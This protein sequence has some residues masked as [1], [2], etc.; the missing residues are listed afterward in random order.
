MQTNLRRLDARD[1]VETQRV[2]GP[3]T[4]PAPVTDQVFLVPDNG[5]IRSSA[6]LVAGSATV[7]DEAR[8]VG[9][10][11]P[12]GT[13]LMSLEP[14]AWQASATTLFENRVTA[15]TLDELKYWDIVTT[16]F[17][18]YIPHLFFMVLPIS[19][20]DTYKALGQYSQAVAHY[21]SVLKYPYL[22]RALEGMDLWQRL[23][24][25]Q[26][27]WGDEL[28][29]RGSPA[30]ARPHY[31]QLVDVPYAVP[32]TSPLYASVAFS[33]VLPHAQETV[34]QL[35]GQPYGSINPRIA[36]AITAAARQLLKIDSGLNILGLSADY[37]P[38]LRFTYLQSAANYLA[39]NAIQAERTFVQFRSQAE[40]ATFE[41]M[42]L[43]NA[44]ALND[45]ALQVEIKRQED[46][47]LEVEAA[48]ETLALTQVRKANAETN[49]QDWD[50]LG[51]ELASVNAALAWASN[52]ANDQEI[53]YTNVQYHGESHDYSGDVED[54]F[55]TVGE[56][57]EWLN[58]DIQR[59]RLERQIAESQGEV[60]VAETRRDQALVRAQVQVL[61][62]RLAEVRLEGSREVLEYAED[63]MFDED[64]WFRLA[65]E[66]QD[67]ARGYLDMAIEAA[68]IMERAYALEF[69]RD[70]HRIRLDYG[71]GGP[72]GLL[73]GD[74]LKQDIASFT[75]DYIRHAE[76]QNP[77][78][79]PLSL[80]EEFPQAFAQF[81]NNGV[82]AFRTDLEI[83]DRRYPGSA[84]RKIKRV[85]MFVEGLIPTNG[86]GGTLLHA[87]VST[88]WR[89]DAGAYVKHHRV[90]PPE[91]M[92]LSSYQFRRDYAVLTPRD[93]VLTLFENLG[94]QGNWTLTIWPS[95]NDLDFGSISDVTLVFYFDADHDSELETHTRALYG[96][97]G[98]RSFVRSAR[99]HEPDEY[100]RLE[101]DRQVSFHVLPAQLPAWVTA[102]E[103]TGLTVRLQ[104]ADGSPPLGAR[105]LTVS[106]ASDGASV[107]A[108]TNT[109]GVLIGDATTM[110]P[111]DAWLHDSPVD[112]FTVAFADGDDLAPILDVHLFLS[113]RFTY[114]ADAA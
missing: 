46:A 4:I 64:L 70:L 93:E 36:E 25:T 66:M 15:T 2:E 113:Y 76:K 72:G 109:D 11:T 90:V 45:A 105:T 80:R 65:A 31:A 88:E 14:V 49:L 12:A 53:T 57:R 17:V 75:L 28:F 63:K 59:N 16:T 19:I 30:A 26:L 27:A 39:D 6:A 114:R 95:A 24:A 73:G 103:L 42:Q 99:M 108:A 1:M 20:A 84:R 83:F 8:S 23:A 32:T 68:Y 98:G 82:L 102:P 38:V 52:A 107:T 44:V 101:R 50:T 91:T 106:R 13:E 74:H 87:G 7:L 34:K 111:F 97:Q 21:Q 51:R 77:I 33:A 29:R 85:E 100:F 43:E 56:V 104:G 18:A 35:L 96:R 79:V 69:D 5:V 71:L 37:A 48:A 58:F 54:F 10:A 67:L 41:R 110:A 60:Q 86:I 78:R 47:A 55:D 61:N 3:I 22:N 81:Q 62:T 40:Q 94:P 112:T 89:A 9:L 92:I